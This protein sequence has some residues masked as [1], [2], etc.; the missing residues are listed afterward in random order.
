M[1]LE[2]IQEQS[3]GICFRET[4]FPRVTCSQRKAGALSTLQVRA[5]CQVLPSTPCILSGPMGGQ[6]L[7]L[8]QGQ[9]LA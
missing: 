9:G 4:G 3:Q 2:P 8:V 1:A 6:G 5:L 7:A